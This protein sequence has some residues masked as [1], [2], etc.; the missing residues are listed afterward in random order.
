MSPVFYFF[1]AVSVVFLCTAS[2]L[3]YAVIKAFRSLAERNRDLR[4]KQTIDI[5]ELAKIEENIGR[6]VG[7][8]VIA[9]RLNEP[10]SDLAH[11]IQDNFLQ[12][13]RYQYFVSLRTTDAEIKN[14][15]EFL[16]HIAATANMIQAG[17]ANYSI[18]RIEYD[19]NDFPYVC[20]EYLEQEGADRKKVLMY[21]GTDRGV[22]IARAYM[23]VD[24]A[25]AYSLVTRM[26]FLAEILPLDA[27]SYQGASE[28]ALTNIPVARERPRL[29]SSNK[30][31]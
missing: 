28:V 12:G 24:E 6:L 31:V 23:K 20:Y 29:V 30:F 7:V 15:D 2:F 10:G 26:R 17:A 11:A 22:G 25:V 27:N 8:T 9:D 5:H 16:G 4:F 21:R 13:V 19:L 3:S 1:A 14:Y 18:R